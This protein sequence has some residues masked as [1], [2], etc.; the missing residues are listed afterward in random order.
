MSFCVTCV[1]VFLY[2][3]ACLCVFVCTLWTLISR[4]RASIN[5]WT[6]SSGAYLK[7]SFINSGNHVTN[8]GYN[9]DRNIF[10]GLFHDRF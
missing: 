7:L 5:I 9:A 1:S 8:N 6:F 4:R 10:T 2:G 3:C